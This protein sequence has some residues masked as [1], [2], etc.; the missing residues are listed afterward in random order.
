MSCVHCNFC[1]IW[2]FGCNI[3][4]EA[5]W[6]RWSDTL[7]TTIAGYHSPLLL[8]WGLVKG[9][10]F[11]TQVPDITNLKARITDDFATVTEDM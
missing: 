6:E 3:S 8:L 9:K 4:K 5:D 2:F 11:S 10:V 1:N 7:T